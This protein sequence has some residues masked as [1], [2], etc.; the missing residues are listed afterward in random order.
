MSTDKTAAQRQAAHTQRLIDQ[1]G[2]RITVRIPPELNAA[3]SA[4]LDRTGDS[5]NSLI[6]RLLQNYL[7][8]R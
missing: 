2:R 3:L 7:A 1:G 5:A 6:L 8:K 4:E